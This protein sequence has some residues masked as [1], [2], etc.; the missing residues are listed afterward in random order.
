ME[1]TLYEQL[2]L[3]NNIYAHS[4]E[5][6]QSGLIGRLI[7]IIN[8]AAMPNIKTALYPHQLR[9]VIG[10]AVH[11]YQM[12]HGLFVDDQLLSGKLGILADSPGSGK[13]YTI[14]AYLGLLRNANLNREIR[15][16]LGMEYSN[17]TIHRGE[18]N[19]HSNRFFSSHHF[20]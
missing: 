5:E 12:T 1:T 13:T 19:T 3:V 2:K 20:W 15:T 14:L 9:S 17:Q 6:K 10:M 4:I 7:P 11:H 16:A 18:L 8:T